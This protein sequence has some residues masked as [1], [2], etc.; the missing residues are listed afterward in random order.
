MPFAYKA[1]AAVWLVVLGLFALSASSMVVGKNVL[2]LVFGGLV[3]PA[4]IL[5]VAVTLSRSATKE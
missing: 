4:V 2:W 5:T 1:L 3:T